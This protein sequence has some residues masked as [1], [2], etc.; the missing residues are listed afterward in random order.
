ME[1]F[2]SSFGKKNRVALFFVWLK[3]RI[4]WSHSILCLVGES[5]ECRGRRGQRALTSGRALASI[6]F[7]GAGV[8]QL[9]MVNFHM[10]IQESF[11]SYFVGN[12]TSRKLE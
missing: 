9:L 5:Y 4:E 3:S 2:Y 11:H 7:Y 6:R 10:E 12:Q 8:F 1:P